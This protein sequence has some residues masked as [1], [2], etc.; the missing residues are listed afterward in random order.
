MLRQARQDW[1]IHPTLTGV[2]GSCVYG[3]GQGLDRR[4]FAQPTEGTGPSMRP[5]S[6]VQAGKADRTP[7]NTL[8]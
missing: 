7:L 5:E 3:S 8:P 4:A 6:R 2:A 1:T